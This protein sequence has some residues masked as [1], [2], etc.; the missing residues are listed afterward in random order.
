MADDTPLKEELTPKLSPV[1]ATSV[2]VSSNGTPV[3][4]TSIAP[5][6]MGASAIVGGLQ[7]MIPSYTLVGKIL[8]SLTSLLAGLSALSA[9]WRK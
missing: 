1:A 5:Y 2:V 8:L 4:P 7:F 3:I 6:L 9:G